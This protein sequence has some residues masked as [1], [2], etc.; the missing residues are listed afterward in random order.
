MRRAAA[1]GF[2]VKKMADMLTL[3]A[4]S[5]RIEGVHPLQVGFV[6]RKIRTQRRSGLPIESALTF[7]P[8]R[9]GEMTRSAAAWAALAWRYRRIMRKVRNDPAR[10][11]Y[12]DDALRP[13]QPD[14][15]ELP[16]FVHAFAEKLSPASAGNAAAAG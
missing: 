10:A 4:G 1:T 2:N 14:H 16:E 3:F 9:L 8:K 15:A 13:P 11:A 5:V 7:Y 6:R 12:I